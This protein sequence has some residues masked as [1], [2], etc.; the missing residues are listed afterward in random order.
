MVEIYINNTLLDVPADG[1]NFP[2]NYSIADIKEPEKRKQS[3]SK[4]IVLPSTKT[5]KVLLI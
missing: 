4:T 5:N 3:F 1:V 2:L